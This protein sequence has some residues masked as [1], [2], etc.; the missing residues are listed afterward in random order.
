MVDKVA[1]QIELQ[2]RPVITVTVG[3][4]ARVV[5]FLRISNRGA[6]IA[7]RLRLEMSQPFYRFSEKND[8]HNISKLHLFTNEIT[9]FAPG[10]TFEIDLS[11]GFNI[12][13]MVGGEN[14]SPDQFTILAT[15]Y[16]G[17]KRYSEKFHVDLRPYMGTRGPYTTSDQLER[18]EQVLERKL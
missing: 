4:R 1:E 15:Y 8:D 18:I 17:P 3:V 13:V 5:F 7:Q 9:T 12:N 10:E 16:S 11:Q 14:I 6:S 2:S